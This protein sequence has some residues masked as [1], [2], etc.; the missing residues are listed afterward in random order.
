MGVWQVTSWLGTGKSL[1]FFYSAS[2]ALFK[3]CLNFQVPLCMCRVSAL[4]RGKPSANCSTLH[5]LWA[6]LSSSFLVNTPRPLPP[7][8]YTETIDLCFEPFFV[9]EI[10]RV[11]EWLQEIKTADKWGTTLLYISSYTAKY[12]LLTQ[13]KI[14]VNN[15]EIIACKL[16]LF[17]NTI[18]DYIHQEISAERE[19]SIAIV[20]A[21]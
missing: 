21:P 1:T 18:I 5:I 13:C 14:I 4:W 2:T 16:E 3:N 7:G 6:G 20:Y 11:I 10:M 12:I 17:K 9:K 8:P 15:V 19:R